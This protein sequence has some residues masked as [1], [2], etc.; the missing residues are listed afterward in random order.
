[1]DLGLHDELA[2]DLG[3]Y[4]GGL[5]GGRRDTA[6]R[7]GDSVARKQLFGLVFVEL[8]VSLAFPAEGA[9]FL[10]SRQAP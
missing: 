9:G 3:G 4:P 10:F 1:V 8:N 7:H 6:P 5:V 2:A